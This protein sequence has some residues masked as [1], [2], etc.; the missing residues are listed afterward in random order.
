MRTFLLLLSPLLVLNACSTTPEDSGKGT[1]DAVDADGD[2]MSGDDDCDDADATAYSGAEEVCDGVDNDCDGTADNNATDATLWYADADGDG[3]GA[4]GEGTSACAAPTET[5]VGA[6][7]DCDDANA[8]IHTGA[9]E[10]DCADPV[11]YNCDGSVG[12]VDADGDLVAA[13]ED[14]DDSNVEINP[15]APEICNG[16]DD[17]CDSV[18]DTDAIDPTTWYADVDVDGYGDD[19]STMSQCDAPVGHVDVGGDCRDDDGKYNPAAEESDCTDPEDY[20]CDGSVG[21]ADADG[22]GVAAC[23]ECNDADATVFPGASELCNG[24][25]DNC[26]TAIDEDSA[27]DA[28]KWYADADADTYGDALVMVASCSQPADYVASDDDCDDTEALTYP[29]ADETC[30]D[31]DDNCD[32]VVDEDAAVDALTWY[33]DA[34]KDGYGDASVM[35]MACEEP[36]D[37]TDDATDCDPLDANVYPSAPEH[38]D[39]VDEDCDGEIDESDAVD[40]LT[41]YADVDE[42]GYG[43]PLVSQPACSQPAG[44]MGNDADCDD[45]SA[46]VNPASA[47]FCD[48]VDNNCD[49]EVDETSAVDTTTFYADFDG[50][51]YGDVSVTTDACAQPESYVYDTQDCDDSDA[52]RYPGATE[53]CD[54]YDNDCD[55]VTD[56][57]DAVDALVYYKDHDGDT[58]GDAA[59]TIAACDLP[60]DYVSDA[61]DCDD[62]DVDE[63]PGADEVCDLDDDDCD[64]EEDE[65]SAVDAPTWFYD[66]DADSYG[67]ATVTHVSCIAPADYV[68]TGTDCDDTYDSV[69]PGATEVCENDRDDDCDGGPN[70]C[71][72]SGSADLSSADNVIYGAATNDYMGGTYGDSMT[73]LATADIDGDGSADLIAGA[74]GHDLSSG[75]QNSG[76]AYVFFGPLTGS[77]TAASAGTTISGAAGG[78]RFGTS[79]ASAGDFDGDDTDDLIIGSEGHN[80][81]ASVTDTG[82]VYIYTGAPLGAK[83][84][85]NAALSIAGVTQ[86]DFFGQAVAGIGDYDG[87]GNDDI[88]AGAHKADA[89]ATDAGVVAVYRGGTTGSLSFRITDSDAHILGN[90]ASEYLGKALDGSGDTDGDG[91]NELLMGAPEWRNTS[92]TGTK[93]GSAYIIEGANIADM[94]VSAADTTIRGVS[95]G[96]ELG[97]SVSIPGD[98]DGDGYDDVLVASHK[99]DASA[100]DSGAVYLFLGP[101][102]SSVATSAAYATFKG[103]AASDYA[104]RSIDGAGDVNADG[105]LDLVIGATGYDQSATTTGNGAL[106]LV[107]GPTSGSLTLSSADLIARGVASAD[108]VGASI[109]GGDDVDDDGYDDVMTGGAGVDASGSITNSG[110]VYLLFGTGM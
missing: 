28:T 43:D 109:H 73:S 32:G 36:T 29:G 40:A 15:S 9:D 13:C 92:S 95:S 24:V 57:G 5:D 94:S 106:Y 1:G 91:L 46:D 87:D 52:D 104:G 108:A 85:S 22:D 76:R 84:L 61:T 66:D 54:G 30:N 68:A 97:N 58:Y 7:G 99:A 62:T 35:M 107:Y 75:N 102:S 77:E 51:S 86:D 17:N 8:A 41:W 44:T 47:E 79:I 110:G 78:D 82:G 6:A 16:L 60:T 10:S 4:D 103:A 64:G 48:L 27:I 74:Y 80:L 88:A 14:C 69:N 49:G 56:E 105:S 38:C 33:E 3:V 81:S 12:Y 55:A 53:Y 23:V 65:D 45:L 96:D 20:N 11:D 34:D 37:Y 63:H 39:G 42:D 101:M 67:D 71:E 83:V 100:T 70:D 25:D 2:G 19:A 90:T 31:A 18:T 26:D 21:Y 72:W 98:W 89:G 50:D 93:Y 59:T